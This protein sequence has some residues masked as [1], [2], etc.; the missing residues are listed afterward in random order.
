MRA[1]VA[2]VM[3]LRAGLR[4]ARGHRAARHARA[5]DGPTAPAPAHGRRRAGGLRRARRLAARPRAP[6]RVR[7]VVARGRRGGARAG[8]VRHGGGRRARAQG[9]HRGRARC[10]ASRSTLSRASALF[11][12][13]RDDEGRTRLSVPLSDGHAAVR[14]ETARPGRGRGALLRRSRSW[15]IAHRLGAR[16]ADSG[17]PSPTTWRSRR[18]SSRRPASPSVLRGGR[19]RGDAALPVGRPPLHAR[20]RRDGRR[21]PRVRRARS[22]ARSTRGPSTE[23]MRGLFLASMSHD[24]KAPLNAILGFAELRRART[25]SPTGSARA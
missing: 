2:R 16:L 3:E 15:P 13:T 11:A 1:S 24:L 12:V 5:Q 7:D 19:I 22:S 25:R 21:L 4:V 6:A 14:F 17:G 20:G 9:R 23:R 18:A 10:T 8:G